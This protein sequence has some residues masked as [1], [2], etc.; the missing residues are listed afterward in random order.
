VTM[1]MVAAIHTV[2]QDCVDT[3]MHC[4]TCPAVEL[5][6]DEDPQLARALVC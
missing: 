1:T 3:D 6:S 4:Y 2:I 5:C